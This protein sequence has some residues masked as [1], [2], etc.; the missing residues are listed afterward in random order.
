MENR[1]PLALQ[2]E[3]NTCLMSLY[4]K[5][6]H[7]ISP[8]PAVNRY[9]EADALARLQEIVN[10][11]CGTYTSHADLCIRRK[12]QNSEAACRRVVAPKAST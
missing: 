1:K 3:Q 11:I 6:R 4:P 10:V 8:L 2:G 7:R 5:L 12:N 9:R